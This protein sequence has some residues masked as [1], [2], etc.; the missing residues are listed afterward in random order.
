MNTHTLNKD[1]QL[2]NKLLS[3]H[4]EEKNY[5]I[6]LKYQLREPNFEDKTLQ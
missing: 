3:G 6:F 2:N 5:E 1:G 4:V